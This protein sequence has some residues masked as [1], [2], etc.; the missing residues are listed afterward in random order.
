M[1]SDRKVRLEG[2]HY[3]FCGVSSSEDKVVVTTVSQF[4][5]FE[6]MSDKSFKEW[7]QI[8]GL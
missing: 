4:I 3:K 7:Q 5:N 1:K 2:A 8:L 6:R